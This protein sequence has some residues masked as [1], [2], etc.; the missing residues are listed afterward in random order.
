MAIYHF[1]VKTVSRSH[2]RSAVAAAAYRSGQKLFDSYYG[3]THDYTRKVGVAFEKIFA[4]KDC[5]PDLL[6]REKLWN[7][8][9][10][11]EPRRNS[12]VAREFEVALPSELTK[13][14]Q[15]AL[16]EDLCK[17]IVDRHGVIVDACIH[18]PHAHELETLNPHAHILLTTRRAGLLGLGEK[19]RELD[20]EKSG[21]VLFWR[22]EVAKITNFHLE[23]AGKSARVD[24]RSLKD[25]GIDRA[26]QVHEGA[27]VKALREKGI[28]TEISRHNDLVKKEAKERLDLQRSLSLLAKDESLTASAIQELSDN[29][30]TL[31]T[32]AKTH[33]DFQEFYKSFLADYNACTTPEEQAQLVQSRHFVAEMKSFEDSSKYLRKMDVEP[34][35]SKPSRSRLLSIFFKPKKDQSYEPFIVYEEL[36][37][38][39]EMHFK[40]DVQFLKNQEAEKKQKQ[41]AEKAKARQAFEREKADERA[42]LEYTRRRD[43]YYKELDALGLNGNFKNPF[44]SKSSSALKLAGNAMLQA[45]AYARKNEE[46]LKRLINEKYKI[47]EDLIPQLD[48][49]KDL[50]LLEQS[51]SK[52]KILTSNSISR[53]AQPFLQEIKNQ[54]KKIENSSAK[55]TLNASDLAPKQRNDHDLGFGM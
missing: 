38:I 41:E 29:F 19:S 47:M 44:A 21:E 49:Q 20:C 12:T 28:E 22:E 33:A 24:H 15:I 54:S 32:H 17:K 13:D 5:M 25:Q 53:K 16:V 31:K 30:S 37:S 36:Q 11:A 4:P 2:G 35:R 39:Y 27:Q 3:L 1:S 43:K 51:I 48:D 34:S 23:K 10:H 18:R 50:D 46:E 45:E 52:D 14:Q 40:K 26:P 42:K 8:A 55:R 9:E 7:S 6:D